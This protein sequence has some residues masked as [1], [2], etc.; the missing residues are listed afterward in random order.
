MPKKEIKAKPEPGRSPRSESKVSI[1]PASKSKADDKTASKSK[2]AAKPAPKAKSKTF[3]K[4]SS[5]AK[6]KPDAK[7]S[8]K[9]RS[10]PAVDS[11]KPDLS[12]IELDYWKTALRELS[13]RDEIMKGLIGKYTDVRLKKK[14]DDPFITLARA[15]I[16]QQI[17][18]KAAGSIW[19]R[20]HEG[21]N[22]TVSPGSIDRVD[23][24]DLRGYG[25]SRSKALYLKNLA[26]FFLE[27]PDIGKLTWKDH[28]QVRKSLLSIKGVGEWTVEMYA[29]FHMGHPDIFPVK[30]IGIIRAI[31]KIYG[32]DI[33]KMS[34]AEILDYTKKWRPYRT[35]VSLFLWR[36]LDSGPVQ[37]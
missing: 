34:P 5:K 33:S 13:E 32:A 36:E 22:K 12:K 35:V 9:A 17:S 29:I 26:L 14:H 3:A 23:A 16:G 10:V 1:K 19:N 15:I 30:D 8:L 31:Q 4:S 6:S 28:D 2:T 27:N 24:E 20:M 11:W 18:V 37:Y 25:L 21:L 7:S